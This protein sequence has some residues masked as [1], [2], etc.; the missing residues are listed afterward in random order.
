[1]RSHAPILDGPRFSDDRLVA[2]LEV[3]I[4][5]TLL[6]SAIALGLA[7]CVADTRPDD[8]ACSAPT[9]EL[10]LTVRADDMV[11]SDP[12]V[13]RDQEVTLVISAQ[14]DGVIHLHGYDAELPA[15]ELSNGD[16][17][18]LIFDASRSGQYPIELHR[19]DSPQGINVGILTVHE[20]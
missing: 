15:T 16:E 7:A 1:M 4:R 13:C 11:P 10:E 17:L 18:S 9:I 8:A 5:T 3:T 2:L 19:M 20:P 12:S 14:V 6:L